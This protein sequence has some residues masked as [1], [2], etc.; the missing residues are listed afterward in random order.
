MPPNDPEDVTALLARW[1]SGTS[2]DRNR[3]FAA[4]HLELRRIAAGYMRRERQDHTLQPSALVN[5]A[6]LRLVRDR[7]VAWEDRAH[8]YGIAARVMRQVLVDHARK[9]AAGKR[10]SDAV[11]VD[12]PLSRVAAPGGGPDLDVIALHDALAELEALDAR[13]AEIVELRYFGGLTEAE[14]AKVKALSPATVRREIAAARFW[15]GRRMQ[16]GP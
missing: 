7:R 12:R 3:L 16:G 13:Q 9:H 15:L 10:G 14:V 2:D 4:V 5:E 11:R 6:Y 1:D 8:F